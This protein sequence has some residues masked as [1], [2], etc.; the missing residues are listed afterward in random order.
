MA[1]MQVRNLETKE[2]KR[3]HAVDAR[4]YVK[5]DV[6]VDP[7]TKARIP[8]WEILGKVSGPHDVRPENAVLEDRVKALEQQKAQDGKTT[9][10]SGT[11]D[12]DKPLSKYSLPELKDKAEEAGVEDFASMN[13]KQL[14]AAIGSTDKKE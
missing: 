5:N 1:Y 11:P 8:K 4:E 10:E 14:I 7:K 6:T 12:A 13:K 3:V 2:V 9:D